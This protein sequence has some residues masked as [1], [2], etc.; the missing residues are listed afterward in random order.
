M[1]DWSEFQFEFTLRKQFVAELVGIEGRRRGIAAWIMPHSW[2]EQLEKARRARSIASALEIDGTSIAERRIA[3]LLDEDDSLVP[4]SQSAV[5]QQ[6]QL[7]EVAQAFAWLRERFDRNIKQKCSLQDILELHRMTTRSTEDEHNVPG[8]FRLYEVAVDGNVASGHHRGAPASSLPNLMDRFVEWLDSEELSNSVHPVVRAL[9]AHFFLVSIRPFGQGNG[10]VSRFI[11]TGLLCQAGFD[12]PGFYGIHDYYS[13]NATEYRRLLQLA[14]NDQPFDLTDFVAFGLRGIRRGLEEVLSY[15]HSNFY[16]V[17][18]RRMLDEVRIRRLSERR[19]V[20]NEREYSLLCYLLKITQPVETLAKQ[21]LHR[22]K[23][24]E[25]LDDPFTATLYK[26]RTQRTI[27]REIDRLEHHGFI[28]CEK[29][30]GEFFVAI[31]YD[32]IGKY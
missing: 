29:R 25:L 10:R 11:E 9:V 19:M 17:L 18:Y 23:L 32:A 8:R 7:L 15:I 2:V 22:I 26:G 14:R 1:I 6:T 20:I 24:A 5:S 12:V 3:E 27:Q 31:D 4:S 28:Q 16:Q 21:R 30:D 13:Q